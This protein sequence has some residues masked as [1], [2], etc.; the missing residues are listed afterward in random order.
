MS[1]QPRPKVPNLSGSIKGLEIVNKLVDS[2]G[3]MLTEDE[4]RDAFELRARIL[5]RLAAPKPAPPRR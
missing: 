3:W 2:A 1:D 5:R 4:A